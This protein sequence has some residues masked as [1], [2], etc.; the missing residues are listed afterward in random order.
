MGIE[1]FEWE[2]MNMYPRIKRTSILRIA[3]KFGIWSVY[4]SQILITELEK[5]QTF[6]ILRKFFEFLKLIQN[7]KVEISHI[8]L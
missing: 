7:L 2:T 1:K 3:I 8:N 4:N 5:L 6:Q